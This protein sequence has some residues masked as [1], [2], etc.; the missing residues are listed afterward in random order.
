HHQLYPLFLHDALPIS[1]AIGSRSKAG[2][3]SSAKVR[4]PATEAPGA[5][6]STFSTP[7][8]SS[9]FSWAMISSGVPSKGASSRT[10]ESSSSLM[11]SEEH[12][13]ELQSPD[14]IV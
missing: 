5:A 9:R 3:I 11:R 7:P 12:T 4:R 13:S 2:M 1:S 8:A 6:N 10:N 14:H